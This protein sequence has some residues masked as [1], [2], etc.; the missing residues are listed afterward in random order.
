[1]AG[2]RKTA[3]DRRID[4]G[5]PV[6]GWSGRAAPTGNSLTGQYCRLE[7]LDM[8]HAAGLLAAFRTDRDDVSWDYLP[9]GPFDDLGSFEAFLATSC[10]GDDP[11]FH[12]IIDLV[13]DR[14]VGMASY[15]RP[16]PANGVIEVG[17]IN[18][19]PL[20]QRRP[21]ATESMY[22]MMRQ[23]FADWGYRRYEWKC[24]NLN[25]RSKRAAL[26]LGFSHEGLFRQ[27]AVV[28]CHNRDT[29]WFSI[30][31]SEWPVAAAAFE[32]WL[33]PDNF[34]AAGRQRCALADIRN[35]LDAA[36]VP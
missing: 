34:D 23:V 3:R 1:M 2:T 36:T 24:N 20:M 7:P 32:A 14:P 33:A 30:L 28:K 5:P 16:D 35:G 18:F 29:A 13:T 17:H 4:L 27:A 9:Y 12:T 21:S 15:L 26:R 19:S 8:D 31:D 6:P 10:L 22:L 11:M 25:D